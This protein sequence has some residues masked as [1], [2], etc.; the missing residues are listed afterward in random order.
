MTQSDQTTDQKS[1]SPAS[2]ATACYVVVVEADIP[3]HFIEATYIPRSINECEVEVE[4]DEGPS[5]RE[6]FVAKGLALAKRRTDFNLSNLHET[7]LRV[8]SCERST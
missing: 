7:T 5:D 3:P 2:A 8:L 6:R 4:V 1:T